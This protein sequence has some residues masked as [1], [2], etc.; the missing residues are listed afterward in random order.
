MKLLLPK[1][2]GA[3]FMLLVPFW[4]GVAASGFV[5]QHIPFF[6][7]WLLLYLSTY[8]MLL[9]FKG[10]KQAY[11]IKWTL[12]YFVPALLL[13]LIPLWMRP[14]LIF[15]ALA[16]VPFF[17][18]N[19][20]F[21]WK[22]NERAFLNDISAVTVF[23]IAGLASSYLYGAELTEGAWLGFAASILFFTGS[24]FFVKTMVREKKNIIY[25]RLSW[26]YHALV[27]LAWIVSGYYVAAIAFLPS[28]IRAYYLYGKPWTA[29]QVGFLEIGNAIFFFILM[30]IQ[31][32]I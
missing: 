9:I 6:I 13:L 17:L 14:A 25:K 22:K 23:A 29:K 3:W 32:V 15:F 31:I 16:M 2:H 5:W 8:P 27:P 28:S 7:G 12:I 24:T 21:S 19:S 26:I 30:V 4:L 11:Y 10:K 1:Q 18:I 20:Y